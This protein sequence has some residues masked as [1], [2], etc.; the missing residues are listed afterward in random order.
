[1]TVRDLSRQARKCGKEE[2]KALDL[3]KKDI[4]KGNTEQ[5]R[6]RAETVIRKKNEALNL[7]KL[8]SRV[9]AVASRVQTVASMQKVTGSMKGVVIKIDQSM[10]S[11]NSEQMSKLMDT[12]ETQFEDL[13]VQTGYM[14][15][16]ISGVTTL[17]MPQNEVDLLMRQVADESGL[18][19]KDAMQELPVQQEEMGE[20]ALL[21][22]RL[23]RHRNAV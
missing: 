2:K 5:A 16:A 7:M 23:H 9:D 13:D 8:A 22:E 18:T 17:T 21:N 14:E 1:F 3:L 19:L 15:G 20:E 4:A 12:F 6:I 11:M 10:K